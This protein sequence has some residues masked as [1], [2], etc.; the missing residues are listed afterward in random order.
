VEPVLAE[1]CAFIETEV[2]DGFAIGEYLREILSKVDSPDALFDLIESLQVILVPSS[3]TSS[4]MDVDSSGRPTHIE[5]SCVFGV[6]LR[7]VVHSCKRTFEAMSRLYHEIHLYMDASSSGLQLV[8]I[9]PRAKKYSLKRRMIQGNDEEED[10]PMDDVDRTPQD[11]QRSTAP[12]SASS[13]L[14][15]RSLLEKNS[16]DGAFRSF[17]SRRQLQF[18][19]H[20]MVEEIEAKIGTAAPQE[21]ESEVSEMLSVTPDLP[22]AH[23]VRYLNCLMHREYQGAVDSLHTYFDYCM[24]S[25]GPTSS[26]AIA[27]ASAAAIA[28]SGGFGTHGSAAVHASATLGRRRPMMQYAVLNLAALHYQFGHRREAMLAIQETVRVAQ[29]NGD[30]VCVVFAL[31][32]LFRLA[33]SNGGQETAQ[34]LRRCL[35]RA[36]DLGLNHVQGLSHLVTAQY[37][38]LAPSS[39]PTAMPPAVQGFSA[40]ARR[41]QAP[42]VAVWDSLD[43]GEQSSASGLGTYLEATITAMQGGSLN[44]N[45]RRNTSGNGQVADEIYAIGM[46]DDASKAAMSQAIKAVNASLATPSI[47]SANAMTI[48]GRSQLLQ[49]IAWETYGHHSLSWLASLTHLRHFAGRHGASASDTC[50]SICRLAT[51]QSVYGTLQHLCPVGPKHLDKNNRDAF[52]GAL[53]LLLQ[54]KATYK[55][56][57]NNLIVQTLASLLT[58]RAVARNDS[59]EARIFSSILF[60]LTPSKQSVSG[61]GGSFFSEDLH[62]KAQIQ[63]IEFLRSSGRLAEAHDLIHHLKSYSAEISLQAL[64]EEMDLGLSQIFLDSGASAVSALQYNLGCLARTEKRGQETLQHAAAIKLAAVVFKMGFVSRAKHVLEQSLPHVVA[65]GTLELK[66][67][68]HLLLAKCSLASDAEVPERLAWALVSLDKAYRAH[69]ASCDLAK[70]EEDLYLLARVHN[71]LAD[72]FHESRQPDKAK[73]SQNARD[74]AAR[75]FLLLRERQTSPNVRIAGFMESD[76][77]LHQIAC[78]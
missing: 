15:N 3:A 71:E 70:T 50:L 38:L 17:V 77:L 4:A 40:I 56:A 34:L 22:R 10:T 47:H 66:G 73:E 9:T 8:K 42:A 62:I 44:N 29:Q 37:R 20:S 57:P 74:E 45:Q 72:F 12:G 31:T 64:Q 36:R 19:L 21:V 51:M 49:S 33:S 68:L 1:M 78:S 28:A 41:R 48:S 59:L 63:W 46:P 53:L 61:I 35:N 14:S 6:F 60:S 26:A 52:A 69:A 43:R 5:R 25:G 30:H 67:E 65:H 55:Y 16:S 18:H 2:T 76:K 27:T 23:F 7:R 13:R 32:W 39:I 24:R 11:R 75:R 58:K 54:A